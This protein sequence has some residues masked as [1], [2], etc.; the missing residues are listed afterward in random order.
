MDRHDILMA[1]TSSSEPIACTLDGEGFRRRLAELGAVFQRGYLGGER[2]ASGVR[3]RF[4]SAPGLED[5]LRSLAGREHA[6]CRFFRFEIRAAGDEIWWDSRVDSPEA[7]PLL[8]EL[9]A[10]AGRPRE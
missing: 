4:R 3:W 10:L 2:T 8:E 7:Q 1:R 6:C 9:F 5:Q